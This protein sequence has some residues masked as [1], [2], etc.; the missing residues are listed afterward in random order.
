MSQVRGSR[1][2]SR[3]ASSENDTENVL[4]DILQATVVEAVRRS[5]RG[6]ILKE[7]SKVAGRMKARDEV[8]KEKTD[9]SD[10]DSREGFERKKSLENAN[11]TD[12]TAEVAS[13][14]QPLVLD[15]LIDDFGD[16][17]LDDCESSGE[18]PQEDED[19]DYEDPSELVLELVEESDDEV[20]NELAEEMKNFEPSVGNTC[21]CFKNEISEI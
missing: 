3:R 8:E 14:G 10:S 19:I 4:E 13:K 7:S 9:S 1:T 18:V 11:S 20:S 2:P 16:E 21:E 12:F 6:R 17:E 5:S 15:D